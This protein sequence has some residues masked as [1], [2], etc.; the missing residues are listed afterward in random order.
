MRLWVENGINTGI[1]QVFQAHQAA[2]FPAIEYTI[3]ITHTLEDDIM[4]EPFT[5]Q[6]GFYKVPTGP[7]L[8]ATLDDDAVEKYRLG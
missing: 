7:G 1:S 6:R 5:M 2:A 8:G 3:S 4:K